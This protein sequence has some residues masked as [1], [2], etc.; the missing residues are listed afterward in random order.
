MAT[1]SLCCRV[2]YCRKKTWLRFRIPLI[3]QGL[4]PGSGSG[5]E[6]NLPFKSDGRPRESKGARVVW[7]VPDCLRFPDPSS[8]FS[9]N[10][11]IIPI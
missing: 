11:Q 7:S 8:K 6:L 3:F 1:I 4:G 2:C 5:A 10:T 9:Q